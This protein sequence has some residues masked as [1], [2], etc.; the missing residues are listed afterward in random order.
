M[1]KS[2]GIIVCALLLA[3]AMVGGV[4][5]LFELRFERGD[6]YP[7][8]STLR[9]DPL[10]ASALYESLD[11]VPGLTARRYFERTFKESDGRERTLMVLGLAPY[12][13]ERLSRTEFDTI[14]QFAYN[15]GRVVVA[16]APEIYKSPVHPKDETPIPKKEKTGTKDSGEPAS[17]PAPPVSKKDRSVSDEN[18]PVSG[19]KKSDE[20]SATN[21]PE[22]DPDED[23]R[24]IVDY[25]S[26]QAEW[27]FNLDF[28]TLATNDDGVLEF[29]KAHHADVADGLPAELDFHTGLFFAGLTNGWTRVYERDRQPL[30]VERRLGKGS[31]LLVA[32]AY[33]FSNEAMLK[34]PQAGLLAWTIAGGREVIFDEAHLGVTVD[35]GVAS[36]MRKYHLHGLIFSLL[37]L[38]GLFVWKNST[39]LVPSCEAAADFTPAVTGKDAMAGFVNLLRRG[40]ARAAILDRIFE[41]WQKTRNRVTVSNEHRREIESLMQQ[42][43]ARPAGQRQPLALYR[44]ISTILKRRK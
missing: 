17:P 34:N 35:P 42:E 39:S 19:G 2:G 11:R 44:T 3:A 15:G 18:P 38:A 1:L 26:L 4:V 40:I 24:G 31:V 37:L 32:D 16:Y 10:G 43:S 14:Q 12:G 27:G 22:D 21:N 5:R 41:E 13:L 25:T 8:Y 30:M 28:N 33:Y 36:L 6:I 23:W 9:S 7:P 20:K 29:P